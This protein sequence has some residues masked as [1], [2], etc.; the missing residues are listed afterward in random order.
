MAPALVTAALSDAAEPAVAM[1]DEVIAK[2]GDRMP[3]VAIVAQTAKA[4]IYAGLVVRART[5]VPSL[6]SVT[7]TKLAML[8]EE[9]KDLEQQLA[10]WVDR[11]EAAFSAVSTLGRAHPELTRDPVIQTAIRDSNQ[12]LE[13]TPLSATR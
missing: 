11:E 13:A 2:A 4:N 12:A 3:N 10:P 9:H 1:L 8:M 6:S 7:G 5:M